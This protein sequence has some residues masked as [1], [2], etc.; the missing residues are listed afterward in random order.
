MIAKALEIRDRLTFIP[1]LAIEMTAGNIDLG[2]LAPDGQLTEVQRHTNFVQLIN[3]GIA[4]QRYFLRR[5]GYPEVAP[6]AILLTR[7]TG[8][9][10]ATADPYEWG[11]RTFTVAHNYICEH[12]D[13][14]RDGDV[15]DV[16]FILGETTE[17]KISER[18]TE[19]LT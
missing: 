19:P 14:L 11:D 13:E 15:I 10:R 17:K 3:D 18:I 12:F 4:A 16:E 9:G 6:Y 8:N 5:C 2:R 7:L 1:V